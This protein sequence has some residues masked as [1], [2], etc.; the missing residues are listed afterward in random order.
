MTRTMRRPHDT[1]RVFRTLGLSASIFAAWASGLSIGPAARGQTASPVFVDDSP[2]AID[3]IIR[4]RE[5]LSI[6][7]FDEAARVVQL[8]LDTEAERL[9][10][11]SGDPDLFVPVRQSLHALLLSSPPLLERYRALQEPNAKRALEA[12]AYL[13]LERSRLMTPSGFEAALR[14]AERRIES[15][16][17]NTAVLTLL[18]LDRHPDRTGTGAKDSAILLSTALA[19]LG[20]EA[21]AAWRRAQAKWNGEAGLGGPEPRAPEMPSLSEALTPF[22]PARESELKDLLPRPL[23]SDSLGDRLPLE[24]TLNLRNMSNPPLESALWLFSLPTAMGDSVYVCD[25]QTVTAWNRFTLSR[26]W[27]TP[28]ERIEG[29]RFGVGMAQNFEEISGVAVDGAN[30]VVLSG[31]AIQGAD[32]PRRA[33]VNLDPATGNILWSRTIEAFDSPALEEARFRGPPTIDEGVVVMMIDKDVSRRR[34]EGVYA[35]GVR[36]RDGALEWVR[37]LGSSGS[38]AFGVRAGVFD[39]PAARDGFVYGISR[40]GLVTAFESATGRVAWIRRW[41]SSPFTQRQGGN[42]WESSVPIVEGD[43][44]L[45]VSPDRQAVLKIERATGA[46]VQSVS[47]SK[48]GN[49]EYLVRAGDRLIGVSATSLVSCKLDALGPDATTTKFGEYQT[50]DLRGRVTAFGSRVIAP[51]RDGFEILDPSSNNGADARERFVLDSP[52]QLLAL[53]GQLLAVDDRSIHTYLVW[54]VAERLLNER[55]QAM[56]DDPAPSITFAELSYRAGRPE[57]IV[58]C[59]DR[60]LAIIE[61]RPDDPASAEQQTR[62]FRAIYAMVEPGSDA[63]F[64]TSLPAEMRASLIARMDRCASGAGE[65]VAYLLASGRF[66]ESIDDAAP[67]IEA[68]QS[69]LASPELARAPFVQGES[70]VAAE[71]EATRRLRRLV[72]MRGVAVYEP[73]QRDAEAALNAIRQSLDPESFEEVARRFPVARA[74]VQAWLEASSRYATQGRSRLA[75]QALE[76]GLASATGALPA[77]DPMIGELSGRLIQHLVRSGLHYPAQRLLARFAAEH[78]G[79]RLTEGS[80][81]IDEPALAGAIRSELEL[82]NRRPI[83]GPVATA[84]SVLKGWAI[85]PPVAGEASKPMTNRVMMLSAEDEI[86]LFSSTEAGPLTRVWGDVRDEEFLWIDEAGATFARATSDDERADY[87]VIRRDL[88]SG[89]VLWESPPFRSLFPGGAIDALL[90][91]PTQ[92]FVP[93]IDTPLEPRVWV[94]SVHFLFDRRTL[95]LI[96]R[97]GRAAA[98]DLESGKLLWA[99]QTDVTRL[100]D[101]AFEAGILLIGGGDGPVDFSKPIADAHAADPMIGIVQAIDAR[102]GQTVYRWETNDRV[103]WVRLAPEGFAV[104]GLNNSIVSLDPYRGQV[105]WRAEA[106]QVAL[107]LAAWAMPE[108]L[109]IRTDESDLVQINSE[110]GMLRDHPLDTRDRIAGGFNR[111]GIGTMG[112]LA[113][114]ETR[115]GIAVFDRMGELVGLSQSEDERPLLWAGFGATRAAGIY[116]IPSRAAEEGASA[117]QLNLFDGVSLRLIARAEVPVGAAPDVGPCAMLDGRILITTGSATIV[118]DVPDAPTGVPE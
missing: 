26:R 29:R 28:L 27:R 31:L 56:P 95:V 12:G 108:R 62:L 2:L 61:R 73:F 97:L 68:Y 60:A 106:R 53:D 93:V 90:A 41:Q 75:A 71:F 88:A 55:I 32:V 35:I 80:Q 104:A 86:A 116:P 82:L 92:E 57:S 42:S 81:P 38:L 48:F 19:Y 79:M 100:H 101:S 25:S 64:R 51:I 46:V 17:F 98:F 102:T 115:R 112:D 6:G 59:V 113:T 30:V 33:L 24:S 105:R 36:A 5:L 13:D 96:D 4:M 20:S 83:I 47:A 37:Q 77:D 76:E 52:G 91:D 9:V 1:L 65:R 69:I 34:M 66:H 99:R 118:V 85:L 74:S 78:P 63:A 89:R 8:M 50:G 45:T 103:R 94:T 11:A 110:D 21:P 23:W 7:N 39:A 3:A 40:L 22:S 111:I 109:L 43:H 49:P 70:S 14:L 114:V 87:A 107:S 84:T 16:Q 54:S 10:P 72:Q 58:A 117:V 44:L 15:A 67:A 18:Q